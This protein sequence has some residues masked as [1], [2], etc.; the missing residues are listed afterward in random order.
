MDKNPHGETQTLSQGQA[1]LDSERRAIEP[2]RTAEAQKGQ[3]KADWIGQH[4]RFETD[5]GVAG[6]ATVYEIDYH[7]RGD[8]SRVWSASGTSVIRPVRADGSNANMLAT[9]VKI[10]KSSLLREP[11]R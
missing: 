4:P 9:C 5:E 1:Q 2:M 8:D 3:K 6:I 7:Y 10:E 11:G